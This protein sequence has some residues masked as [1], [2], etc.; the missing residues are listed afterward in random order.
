M[1]TVCR[2]LQPD[3]PLRCASNWKNL[4]TRSKTASTEYSTWAATYLIRRQK[5]IIQHLLP[6]KNIILAK[7]L[8]LKPFGLAE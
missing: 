2:L 6:Q 5:S 1:A 3:H 8:E 4:D 7:N